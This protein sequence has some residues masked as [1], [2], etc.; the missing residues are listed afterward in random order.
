MTR[1]SILAWLRVW[2]FRWASGEGRAFGQAEVTTYKQ[3]KKR[4]ERVWKSEEA[5][6]ARL[7]G[8]DG[9]VMVMVHVGM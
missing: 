3:L 2:N 6:E 9:Y 7:S 5:D 4:G 8:Y 1:R